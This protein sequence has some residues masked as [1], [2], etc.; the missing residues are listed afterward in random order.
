MASQHYFTNRLRSQLNDSNARNL[1]LQAL[2]AQRDDSLAACN[3]RLQNVLST[4]SIKGDPHSLLQDELRLAKEATV[5]AETRLSQTFVIFDQ[6]QLEWKQRVEKLE[7]EVAVRDAV[8]SDA[9]Y[10][11]AAE[12]KR[13]ATVDGLQMQLAN[14]QAE[15]KRTKQN[16][17]R[18]QKQLEAEKKANTKSRQFPA[19][20]VGKSR[21]DVDQDD[22]E[23]V[24]E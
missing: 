8:L 16:A 11:L 21:M 20:A 9:N 3:A 13:S 14:S 2:L 24:D 15:L 17:A 18:L 1:E 10:C 4:T 22:E 6:E 19:T 7:R 23:Y 12:V 5:N